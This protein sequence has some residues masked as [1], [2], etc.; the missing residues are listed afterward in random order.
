MDKQK[1]ELQKMKLKIATSALFWLFK[2]PRYLLLALLLA[3][4]FYE[5]IFWAFNLSLLNLLLFSQLLS[6]SDKLSLFLSPI[7]N[8]LAISGYWYFGLMLILA[9][10]QGLTLS[11]LIFTIRH[12]QKVE[13]KVIGGS[14]VASVLAAIGLGCPTCGTSLVAPV[15]TLFVSGST[16]AISKTITTILL[17]IAILVGLYGLYII[18]TRVA[19][20]RSRLAFD[21][22]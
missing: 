2:M 13:G 20:I 22:S 12:Q 9:L 17:P 10:V 4:A 15:V 11:A 5:F 19:S 8:A 14:A 18:G 21:K 16:V 3:F 7:K 1:L 6:F